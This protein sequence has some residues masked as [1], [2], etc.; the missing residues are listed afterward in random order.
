MWRTVDAK[1]DP[2]SSYIRSLE[3]R[4]NVSPV[5]EM[6]LEQLTKTILNIVFMGKKLIFLFFWQYWESNSGS[7]K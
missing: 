7:Y 4:V 5:K 2:R 1:V 3:I 6:L